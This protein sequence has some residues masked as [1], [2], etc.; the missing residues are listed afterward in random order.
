[1]SRYLSKVLPA[2]LRRVPKITVPSI[3]KDTSIVSRMTEKAMRD[4]GEKYELRT[5]KKLTKKEI[6][7]HF[8]ANSE[9]LRG[10]TKRRRR[11]QQGTRRQRRGTR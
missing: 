11:S 8:R 5:G 4:Y 3:A 10:G 1:M 2:T 9:V 6:Q 7:N